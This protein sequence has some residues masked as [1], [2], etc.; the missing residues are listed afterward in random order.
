MSDGAH[1]KTELDR[2]VW[3]KD[4]ETH[5]PRLHSY[6]WRLS[7]NGNAAGDIVQDVVTKVLR[8]VPDPESV[9]NRLNYLL[10]SVHNRWADWLRET[11]RL[12]TTISFDDPNN[13]ELRAMAA[14]EK[15]TER[16]EQ[17]EEF[18]RALQL[19]VERLEG[20]EKEMFELHLEGL[21]SHEIAARLGV[22]YSLVSHEIN[23]IRNR[24]IKRLQRRF[25]ERNRADGQ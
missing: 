24:V 17:A 9:G 1:E 7:G 12:K 4:C 18:S 10:R 6:A 19:E 15:D 23:V 25:K 13:K 21:K 11:I 8:L 20:R 3:S 14:P 22:H 5:Y 16:D 2:A